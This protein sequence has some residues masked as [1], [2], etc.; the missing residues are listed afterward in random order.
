MSCTV[1]RL[2]REVNIGVDDQLR[3]AFSQQ[4]GLYIQRSIKLAGV[5]IGSFVLF[6]LILL[7]F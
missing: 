1:S 6:F 4:H 2:Y 7:V 3:A 5:I